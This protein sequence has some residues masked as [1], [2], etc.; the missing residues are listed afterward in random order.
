METSNQLK[1]AASTEATVNDDTK[2]T[3]KANNI[4]T[5]E[6]CYDDVDNDIECITV[7]SAS[8]M[9]SSDIDSVSESFIKLDL[10]AKEQKDTIEI[11]KEENQIDELVTI[12]E[13][14]SAAASNNNNNYQ[15]SGDH[16]ENHNQTI[17][18]N[19]NRRYECTQFYHQGNP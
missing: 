8:A 9:N 7:S 19:E 5:V 6:D 16:R 3:E 4:V 18:N 10:D 14:S 12:N 1:V 17:N 2:D 11:K 13:A 15:T